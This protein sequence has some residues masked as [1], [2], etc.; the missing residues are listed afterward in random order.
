MNGAS[1]KRKIRTRLRKHFSPDARI[2]LSDGPDHD[3]HLRI[4]SSQFAG[5][6]LREKGDIIW[7][8]LRKELAPE[9]WQQISLTVGQAPEQANGSPAH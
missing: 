4:F 3:I 9:E 8:V 6:R 2:V 1:L 7:E 5:K